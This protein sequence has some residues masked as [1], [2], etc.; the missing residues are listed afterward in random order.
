MDSGYV[1]TSMVVV[2]KGSWSWILPLYLRG[3]SCSVYNSR[4]CRGHSVG[5]INGLRGKTSRVS[6]HEVG[7]G[8]VAFW[9]SGF[10][11]TGV[12][13]CSHHS[14]SQFLKRV[15]H[16]LEYLKANQGDHISW[17]LSTFSVDWAEVSSISQVSVTLR[18]QSDTVGTLVDFQCKGT[19]DLAAFSKCLER[20]FL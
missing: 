3:N 4:N 19:S 18:S 16:S 1:G 14:H 13:R 11:D 10:L 2:R 17:N 7:V 6:R 20:D 12:G 5:W 8:R 9:M 15:S